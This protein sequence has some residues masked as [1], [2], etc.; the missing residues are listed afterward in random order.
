MDKFQMSGVAISLAVVVLMAIYTVFPK[1]RYLIDKLLSPFAFTGKIL[2]KAIGLI[3]PKFVTE[4]L[5]KQLSG[6]VFKFFLSRWENSPYAMIAGQ[7]EVYAAHRW[8]K[9]SFPDLWMTNIPKDL[10]RSVVRDGRLPDGSPVGELGP[11]FVSRKL[12]QDSYKKAVTTAARRFPFILIFW[13]A[14]LTIPVGGVVSFDRPAFSMSQNEAVLKMDKDIWSQKDV[15]DYISSQETIHKIKV[16]AGKMFV[17]AGLSIGALL[18]ASVIT[19]LLSVVTLLGAWRT[20]VNSSARS[21]ADVLGFKTKESVVRWKNRYEQREIEEEVWHN[22]IML[23]TTFDDTPLIKIGTATGLMGYRGALSSP[24]KGADIMIS[25]A[26]M[27]QG[28]VL[29][30]G[31]T[32]EGKTRTVLKPII[33]QILDLRAKGYS[34]SMFGIDGKAV[35]YHDIRN[36][37]AEANLEAAIIGC[38][39]G[40]YGVDMMDGIEP[41]L[42]ADIISSIIRQS[43]GGKSEG[44]FWPDMAS[45]MMRNVAILARAWELT[46]GGYNRILESNERIYSFLYL[47]RLASYDEMILEAVKD[48]NETM[49]NNRGRFKDIDMDELNDAIKHLIETWI[50]LVKET[51]MGIHANIQRA[52]APFQ[53]SAL[54]KS[55]ATGGAENLTT[56]AECWGRITAVNVSSIEYGIAGRIVTVMLKTLLMTQARKQELMDPSFGTKHKLLFVA[57]EYQDLITADTGSGGLSDSNFWNV[58]RSSGVIGLIA[59]QSITS[60]VQAVGSDAAENFVLQMRNKIFLRVEDTKTINLAKELAG[61]TLRCQVYDNNHFE[62]YEAMKW[63]AGDPLQWDPCSIESAKEPE[64]YVVAA[65]TPLHFASDESNYEADLRFMPNPTTGGG[66]QIHDNSTALIGARQAAHWRAEDKQ[67]KLMT[68][69]N[70]RVDVLNT[71]DIMKMG[72]MH[73]YVLL[74]RAGAGVQD[75]VKLP[76]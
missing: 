60:L 26:D 65:L 27:G 66:M 7:R 54:R 18:I 22:Q 40:E 21:R 17:V 31:G 24:S 41:R 76:G 72:R 12:V 16:G 37:A 4:F 32:G 13:A 46:N 74:Q 47:Y 70:E 49:R 68:E 52:L 3:I 20:Y 42:V 25:L 38:L 11:R 19:S 56:I 29:V 10:Q 51:R 33:K 59:T 14:A 71:E 50:P 48:V 36:I 67:S 6:R 62:S 45:D 30:T 9:E 28:G 64:S 8:P 69:G 58:S 43:G 63:E 61:K 73:A 44:G 75:L 53:S 23:A 35:L 55:F 57:D 15:A 5:E 1:V 39:E 2:A 34:I